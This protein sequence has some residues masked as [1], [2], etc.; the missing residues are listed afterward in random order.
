M[1][2]GGV[3]VDVHTCGHGIFAV[4]APHDFKSRARRFFFS[5]DAKNLVVSEDS[6]SLAFPLRGGPKR[7][8]QNGTSVTSD[9]D[10]AGKE[11]GKV[12]GRFVRCEVV[13]QR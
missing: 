1:V 13:R 12:R 11:V 6:L 8:M 2:G 4:A 7:M 5:L 3:V 10:V 9:N